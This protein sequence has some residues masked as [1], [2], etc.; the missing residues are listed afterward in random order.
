M[1]KIRKK[2]PLHPTSLH[3]FT[4]LLITFA[5]GREIIFTAY[6]PLWDKFGSHLISFEIFLIKFALEKRKFVRG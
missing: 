6:R 4:P 5:S 1:V 2:S 3:F